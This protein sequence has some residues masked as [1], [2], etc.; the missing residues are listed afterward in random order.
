MMPMK[1]PARNALTWSLCLAIPLL[2]GCTGQD[3]QIQSL[4]DRLVSTKEANSAAS[5]ALQQMNQKLAVLNREISSQ[6]SR[7]AEFEA[8]SRTSSTSEQMVV[9][10]QAELEGALKQFTESVAAYRKQYLTP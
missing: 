4:E 8:K 10:Y 2:A 3:G 6:A 1:R 9:K 5:T 7:R